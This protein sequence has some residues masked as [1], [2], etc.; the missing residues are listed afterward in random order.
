MTDLDIDLG[1]LEPKHLENVQEVYKFIE[2]LLSGDVDVTKL[3][4]KDLKSINKTMLNLKVRDGFLK[5]FS[6]TGSHTRTLIIMQFGIIAVRMTTKDMPPH[7]QGNTHMI[8]AALMVLDTAL[9]HE[10]HDDDD[11]LIK[12]MEIASTFLD[13]ANA[14]GYEQGLLDLL[15]LM[16]Q[17]NIPPHVFLDSMTALTFENCTQP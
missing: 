7:V 14:T 10:E 16:S 5:Y 9:N 2:L 3:T 6:A 4:K 13:R 12:G 8:L 15:N 11:I 17:I 1:T